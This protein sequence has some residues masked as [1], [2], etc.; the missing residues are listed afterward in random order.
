LSTS[1]KPR[2]RYRPR[3][4]LVDALSRLAP[5]STSERNAL[6]ARFLS[7]LQMLAAGQHPGEQEWRDLADVVNTVETLVDPMGLLDRAATMPL[8]EAATAAM[9]AAARRY[10]DCGRIG[11]DCPGLQAMRDVIA[12]FEQ[13]AAGF[14]RHAMVKARELTEQRMRDARAGRTAAEVVEL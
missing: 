3:P 7:A 13:C 9:V 12:T 1:K 8:V 14:T 11:L 2:R 5:A 10:G 6:T 4:G